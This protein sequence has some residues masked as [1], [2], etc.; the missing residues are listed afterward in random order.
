MKEFLE[1]NK[2]LGLASQAETIGF[3]YFT[4]IIPSVLSFINQDDSIIEP[5]LPFFTDEAKANTNIQLEENSK[6]VAILIFREF[7]FCSSSTSEKIEEPSLDF[8]KIR[9]ES[10][11][12]NYL[13]IP[14]SFKEY[15]KNLRFVKLIGSI[16]NILVK[17][18][19]IKFRE[20]LSLAFTHHN[21]WKYSPDGLSFS[22]SVILSNILPTYM[23]DVIN[24]IPNPTH[25]NSNPDLWPL[26][27]EISNRIHDENYSLDENTKKW[28]WLVHNFVFYVNERNSTKRKEKY[29][30]ESGLPEMLSDIFLNIGGL[31]SNLNSDRFEYLHRYPKKEHWKD[32]L[33][34]V[35]KAVHK[36]Y[37]KAIFDKFNSRGLLH[38]FYSFRFIN[39]VMLYLEEK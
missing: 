6:E 4:S 9:F 1:N 16:G 13:E 8:V 20:V 14:Q 39:A 38:S 5:L 36:D 32:F 17:N 10:E 27:K 29:V 31:S 23:A 30:T 3:W 2:S 34:E 24:S 19:I 35:D 12:N 22:N 18:E 37:G 21:F 33:I 25:F 7:Y 15:F 28:I 11:T 26:S